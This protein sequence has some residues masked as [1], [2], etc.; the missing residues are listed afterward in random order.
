MRKKISFYLSLVSLSLASLEDPECLTK[1]ARDPSSNNNVPCIF[2]FSYLGKTYTTCTADG[3][4][5]QK[6]WCSTKVD[7]GGVHVE[8]GGNWGL[9]G[10]GCPQEK[11]CP[12]GWHRLSTGCYRFE[13]SEDGV[14]REAAANICEE[15]GGYLVEIDSEEE[16]DELQMFYES[17]VQDTCMYQADALWLGVKNDTSKGSRGKASG[18]WVYTR[19]G[20]S[21]TYSNWYDTE[22]NYKNDNEYCAAIFA[23]S[24]QA[25]DFGVKNFRWIDIGCSNRRFNFKKQYNIKLKALC[26]KDV[27]GIAEVPEIV[28]KKVPI[29]GEDGCREGYAKLATGC[30][31]FKRQPTTIREARNICEE[32]GG[33]LVEIDSEEEFSV[34]EKEWKNV[35]SKNE[36][37]D[38]G[39]SWWIGITDSTEEGEWVTD[40]S[41]NTPQ[42][43]AWSEGEP[44]NW[45]GRVPGEDCAVANLGFVLGEESFNWFDVA[46]GIRGFPT[47]QGRGISFN[48]LCEQK[49]VENEIV[50]KTKCE[51]CEEKWKEI[52]ENKYKFIKTPD[53]TT[54]DEAEAICKDNGGYLAEI[55][56][57]NER[58]ELKEYYEKNVKPALTFLDF[59]KGKSRYVKFGWWIGATDE[60]E[61][62]FWKWRHSGENMTYSAWYQG[63]DLP[64]NEN[65]FSY[66]GADCVGIIVND[67]FIDVD[68][69]KEEYED[70][71]KYEKEKDEKK[72]EEKKL[73]ETGDF[74]WFDLSCYIR[75]VPLFNVK[76]SPLCQ[77]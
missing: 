32:S 72:D 24:N 16:S 14:D 65:W 56:S 34:L 50:I 60:E 59:I 11:G 18:V 22:P 77:L 28:E 5:D 31:M 73:V 9:C 53:G 38:T 67:H 51:D 58:K 63:K 57:E 42:F 55:K 30:Y 61:E 8:G 76:M 2:P 52:G 15:Y 70:E 17:S 74:K 25:N 69:K 40:H 27:E 21:L 7:A 71:K 29:I 48:P 44:N 19:T 41:G 54:R 66:G 68:L 64:K 4:L 6:S 23:D 33:H 20:M 35:T 1:T 43:S 75:S 36:C 13:E 45:G 39:I 46:C 3:H 12:L 37:E 62:G 10:P 47:K 26:E 49:P